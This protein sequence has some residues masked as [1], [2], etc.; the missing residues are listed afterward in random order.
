[1]SLVKNSKF[2]VLPLST[3]Y[4]LPNRWEVS[5]VRYRCDY[6]ASTAKK[7]PREC[8]GGGGIRHVLENIIEDNAIKIARREIQFRAEIPV[9]DLVKILLRFRNRWHIVFDSPHFA[10]CS[11]PQAGSEASRS[12]TNVK[13][14]PAKRGHIF[15][16]FRARAFKILFAFRSVVPGQGVC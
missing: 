4:Q 6:A 2:F 13:H 5:D 3:N 12:T 9:K 14:P 15:E 10:A 11:L 1:M 8:Q 7:C 16:H